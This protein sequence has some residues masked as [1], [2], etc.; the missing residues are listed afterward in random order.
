MLVVKN[1]EL[2]VMVMPLTHTILRSVSPAKFDLRLMTAMHFP[3]SVL[4]LSE[5][6]GTS[7]FVATLLAD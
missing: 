3:C 5:L 1:G 7:L 2:H 4:A 6:I